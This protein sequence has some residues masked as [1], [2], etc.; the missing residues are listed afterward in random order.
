MVTSMGKRNDDLDDA[1]EARIQMQEEA[2]MRQDADN[3]QAEMEERNSD[4]DDHENG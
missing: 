4:G 2:E 1:I 3:K